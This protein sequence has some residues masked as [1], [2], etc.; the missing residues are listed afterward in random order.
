[1]QFSCLLWYFRPCWVSQCIP[2]F[3]ESTKLLN[4]CY[5]ADWLSLFFQCNDGLCSLHQQLRVP[6]KGKVTKCKFKA[7]DFFLIMS[8]RH[9][10]KEAALT[11]PQK[12]LS[13]KLCNKFWATEKE[14]N[15]HNWNKYLPNLTIIC[16]LTYIRSAYC[17]VQATFNHMTK[18]LFT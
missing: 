10:W 1:M 14:Q 13:C 9:E 3:K 7:A 6:G 16:L 11:W 8:P 12:P 4:F 5:F 17:Y 18:R 2:S 15:W